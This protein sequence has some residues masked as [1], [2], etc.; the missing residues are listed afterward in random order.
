MSPRNHGPT[1]S[2]V[3]VHVSPFQ[4]YVE[5]MLMFRY[6][7]CGATP[8]ENH[9]DVL[10]LKS[11]TPDPMPVY[12]AVPFENVASA[13]LCLVLKYHVTLM[14]AVVNGPFNRKCPFKLNTFAVLVCVPPFVRSNVNNENSPAPTLFVNPREGREHRM[15]PFVVED[16]VV[17]LI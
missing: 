5:G 3:A 12:K 13:A 4:A 1:W 2:A 11:V 14:L 16:V 7:V 8:V 9:A 15:L 10:R 6:T 17:E